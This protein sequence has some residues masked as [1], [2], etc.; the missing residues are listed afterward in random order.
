MSEGAI[1]ILNTGF[2]HIEIRFDDKDVIEAARASRIIKDMMRRGY[3]LF[4]H[5]ADD[6]LTR[7]EKFDETKGVYVIADSAEIAPE[8]PPPAK[9]SYRTR[10]VPISAAK[11]TAVG[12]SAGG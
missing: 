2:G 12:R 11:V 3:V 6:K 4:I 9:R 1:D 10:E 5:G 8:Q 7:V